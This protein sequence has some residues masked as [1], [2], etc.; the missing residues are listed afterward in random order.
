MDLKRTL[1]LANPFGF[2]CLMTSGPLRSLVTALEDLGASVWEPFANIDSNDPADLQWAWRTGQANVNAVRQSDGVFAVVNGC[3]PDEG[4]MV[5][6]GLAIAWRKP[7]FFFRDDFRR[8]SDSD[9]YPLN[10]MIFAGYRATTWRNCWY[11]HL[12][13]LANPEGGLVRW[14]AGEEVILAAKPGDDAVQESPAD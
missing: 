2:S 4:V 9:V 10:L 12:D 14:L 3:P 1:Y 7:V 13:E 8:C 6:V 5:E 11:E